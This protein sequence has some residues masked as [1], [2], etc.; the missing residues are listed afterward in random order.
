MKKLYFMFGFVMLLVAAIAISSCHQELT[1]TMGGTT[2]VQL[3]P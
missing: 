1:R 2:K 3:E